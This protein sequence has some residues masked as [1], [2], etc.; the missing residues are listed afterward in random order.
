MTVLAGGKEFVCEAEYADGDPWTEDTKA[1]WDKVSEKFVN[2]CGDFIPE[3]T[4]FSIIEQIRYLEDI[5]DISN[6]L[7]L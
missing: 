6:E 3:E 4:I 2:F 1:D 5:G 7:R